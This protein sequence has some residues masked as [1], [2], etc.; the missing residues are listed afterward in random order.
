MDFYIKD[1]SA[2]RVASPNPDPILM[3]KIPDPDQFKKSGSDLFGSGFLKLIERLK[4]LRLTSVF[5][6]IYLL[7]NF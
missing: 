2:G 5:M 3:V 6:F 4:F 7:L 1:K